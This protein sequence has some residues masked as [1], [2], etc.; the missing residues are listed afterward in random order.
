MFFDV[1]IPMVCYYGYLLEDFLSP[2]WAIAYW[3]M[4]VCNYIFDIMFLGLYVMASGIIL[5]CVFLIFFWNKSSLYI[6]L[7]RPPLDNY[8]I[9][10]SNSSAPWNLIHWCCFNSPWW[11]VLYGHPRSSYGS[12]VMR[13]IW[14][15]PCVSVS[16]V[17]KVA[18]IFFVHSILNIVVI[19]KVISLAGYYTVNLIFL[20]ARGRCYR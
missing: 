3:S 16:L 10:R 1:C 2:H 6:H 19:R 12:G 11:T 9:C 17:Y 15:L 4:I 7:L 20:W 13:C 14:Y 18:S 5:F 8:S